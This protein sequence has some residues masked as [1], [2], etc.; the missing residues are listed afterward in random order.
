MSSSY[1]FMLEEITDSPIATQ[2][3]LPS[4]SLWIG[5]LDLG[6]YGTNELNHI[7]SNFGVIESIRILPDRECAF[8]NYMTVEEAS[9]AK[10]IVLN[11]MSSRLSNVHPVK[12]GF[13]KADVGTNTVM[14]S[15]STPQDTVQGPTRALCK[16]HPN[17][18]IYTNLNFFFFIFTI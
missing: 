11:K 12:V 1:D 9:R 13:G 6:I 2:N 18:P 16:C 15:P 7:F 4:R 3:Q 8:I 10:D 5:Q 14:A 17:N